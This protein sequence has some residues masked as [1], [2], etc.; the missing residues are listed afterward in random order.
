MVWSCTLAKS[1]PKLGFNAEGGIQGP[2]PGSFGSL[3]KPHAPAIP[4]GVNH[5]LPGLGGW[6]VPNFPEP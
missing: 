4:P 3:F 5:F 2:A 6:G 1:Q